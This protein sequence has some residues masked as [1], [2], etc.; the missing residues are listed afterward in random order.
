MAPQGEERSSLGLEQAV[1]TEMKNSLGTIL[2]ISHDGSR[3][4]APIFLLRFLRWFRENCACS[5]RILVGTYG[6]LVPEFRELGE[7]DCFE[8]E[9]RLTYKV[10]R[11]LGLNHSYRLDHQRSLRARLSHCDVRLI[12]CNTIANG[13]ILDFLSFL[14]CPVICHVHE[15][16]GS[17]RHFGPE[18][19]DLVKKY[20]SQ[21]IAVSRAVKRNLSTRHDIPDEQIR[22]ING[23]IPAEQL[24]PSK[25]IDSRQ[26]VRRELGIPLQSK[27][28]CASGS[29]DQR[30]GTDLFLRVAEKVRSVDRDGTVHFVWVGGRSD[31]LKRTRSEI[32]PSLRAFVHFIGPRPVLTPYYD[33]SDIFLLTSREDPFPLVML[34]AASRERPI[35]CFANSGGAAEF[36]EN[37]AGLMVPDFDAEKMAD[38]VMRLLSA[39]ELSQQIGTAARRKVMNRHLLHLAAPEIAQVIQERLRCSEQPVDF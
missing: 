38:E 6:E 36:V 25:V 5:F 21:Y 26:A 10:L 18:N 16:E 13:G 23:F 39:P 30:K 12:Y 4:G 14:R 24:D 22:M 33:A 28:V 29:I 27:L 31:L 19:M 1:S 2:F 20:A 32:D 34:E 37:G 7:V 17:I 9:P 35:L 8:P 15:L 3:T 11:R